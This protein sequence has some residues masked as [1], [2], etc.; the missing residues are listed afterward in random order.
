M[1]VQSLLSYLPKEIHVENFKR[2]K[3]EYNEEEDDVNEDGGI[4]CRLF[5]IFRQQNS[6]EK[7]LSWQ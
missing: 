1:I 2:F 3:E 5:S 7:S 6:L 4:L